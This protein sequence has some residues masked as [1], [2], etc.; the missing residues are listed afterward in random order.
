MPRYFIFKLP[1]PHNDCGS[2]H[3]RKTVKQTTIAWHCVQDCV[4][5][6]DLRVHNHLV[7]LIPMTPVHVLPRKWFKKGVL[8]Y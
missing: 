2:A 5:T 1:K 6:L 3:S 4:I 8:G 7:L